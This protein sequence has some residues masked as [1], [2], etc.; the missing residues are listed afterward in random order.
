MEHKPSKEELE[1]VSKYIG[2]FS[3]TTFIAGVSCIAL[4]TTF[5][6]LSV[7]GS[8]PV[9]VGALVNSACFFSL[10]DTLHNTMHGQIAGRHKKLKWIDNAIGHIAG[11]IV[12]M[13]FKGWKRQHM[14]H[15]S[16]TNV[17]GVDPN[18]F[19]FDSKKSLIS[20]VLKG[21]F[22]MHLYA[23]PF[24]GK[25]LLSNLLDAAGRRVAAKAMM[26]GRVTITTA[27]LEDG[28]YIYRITTGEELVGQGRFVV[29]HLW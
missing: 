22:A 2:N 27:D 14:A 21:Y 1:I 19:H 9:I 11:V 12:Q 17:R 13:G 24:I 26:N 4:V 7:I 25:K 3:W 29:E 10:F 20:F 5:T 18:F 8:V 23:I 15:H 16:N 28:L 6:T